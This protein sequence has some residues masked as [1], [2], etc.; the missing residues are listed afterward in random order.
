MF[1]NNIIIKS[2][3][4]IVFGNLYKLRK[5]LRSKIDGYCCLPYVCVYFSIGDY[6]GLPNS[7]KYDKRTITSIWLD[8]IGN[9]IIFVWDKCIQKNCRHRNRRWSVMSRIY[10]NHLSITLT[11]SLSRVSAQP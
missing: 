10:V 7:S 9:G 8:Y 11:D 2:T 3:Y 4:D 6:K 1:N 5:T